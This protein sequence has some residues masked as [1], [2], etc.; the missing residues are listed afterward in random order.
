[1][2]GI[3]FS[4]ADGKTGFLVE[5][6]DADA[7]A[8]R[9]AEL[10]NSPDLLK[11]FGLQSIRRVQKHFTWERVTRM[12]AATYEEVIREVQVEAG[13]NLT[14][15]QDLVDQ[16][17]TDLIQTLTQTHK[18]LSNQV[19]HFG[20][21]LTEALQR[22][23][24]ILVCGNGGSAADAQHFAAELTGRF[25][26][27][28]RQALPAIALTA[29]TVLLTAWAND[30]SF[31]KIFS[32]QVEA[33]G[34]P[35]DVLL[36]LSTSGKSRNLVEACKTARR[37]GV[38]SLALLGKDG[39][40][41]AGI[42]DQ[43]VIV[44]AEQTTRIQET[45]ILIL[46]LVCELI[47][48]NLFAGP[49]EGKAKANGKGSLEELPITAQGDVILPFGAK[50]VPASTPVSAAKRELPRVA[51]SKHNG[52]IG[53]NEKSRWKGNSGNRRSARAR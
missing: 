8:V 28:P 42:A 6:K 29:D 16:G 45:Q 50:P 14:A 37:R 35:G 30:V 2:G 38:T 1:V 33:F 21:T 40:S 13:A 20:R 12:L 23:N 34:Q 36:L 44:P 4:V 32:R 47:E 25:Q 24:K 7:L 46:H 49:A 15:Q 17:F 11:R 22:G 18:Q 51:K 53:N 9:L 27:H 10:L 19:I 3:K 41:L 26:V 48:L 5:P 39:G 31:D 43:S 52:D